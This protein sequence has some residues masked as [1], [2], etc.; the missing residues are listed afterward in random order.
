MGPEANTVLV[1]VHVVNNTENLAESVPVP[2]PD[3]R[4]N[5]PYGIH[6]QG[7]NQ[8]AFFQ[9]LIDGKISGQNISVA[10]PNEISL[11]LSISR[12]SVA[13]AKIL[14]QKISKHAKSETTLFQG[15]VSDVYDL[16]EE[17]QKAVVFSYRAV[18]AF[19]NASIPPEYMYRK[20][21]SKGITEEYRKE[22]IERWVSTS[23]KVAAI[24][25][26]V[27]GCPPPTNEQ[28]WQQFKKLESLRNEIIHSKSSSGAAT[29]SELFSERCD[30]Y[31]KSSVS[32][33]DYFIKLDP[34]NQIFPL[35]F[36]ES[37]VKVASV[38]DTAEHLEVISKKI[39]AEG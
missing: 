7:D 2:T 32:L 34:S 25:P 18:E 30:E 22:Q 9:T 6:D 24:L 5:K 12:K 33:L 35:G 20:T 39:A 28:F 1:C 11:S 21:N 37:F 14:R 36:G 3:I 8:T 23:E 38:P 10:T 13:A 4:S 26:E 31:I 19:C 16:L 17:M 27:L 29:L 15:E